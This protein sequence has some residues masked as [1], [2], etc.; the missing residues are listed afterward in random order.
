LGV[1]SAAPPCSSGH[2]IIIIGNDARS[3]ALAEWSTTSHTTRVFNNGDISS[4][5]SSISSPTTGANVEIRWAFRG[6]GSQGSRRSDSG[7]G[8]P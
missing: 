4:S 1:A 5:V 3:L 7:G 8:S 6:R 2:C